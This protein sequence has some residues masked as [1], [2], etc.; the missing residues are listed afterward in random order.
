MCNGHDTNPPE[1]GK[2][3]TSIMLLRDHL[4]DKG[5]RLD[6]KGKLQ[7]TRSL[8]IQ[9]DPLP[10]ELI[11]QAI[12]KLY[13]RYKVGEVDSLPRAKYHSELARLRRYRLVPPGKSRNKK[14]HMTSEER[15]AYDREYLRMWREKKSKPC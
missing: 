13:D 9:F 3:A 7:L 2:I 1:P 14:G 8:P 12:L 6:S 5:I 11:P 4:D 10:S 15:K